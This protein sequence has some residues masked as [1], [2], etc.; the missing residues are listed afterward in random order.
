GIADM[1]V[2]LPEWV[3]SFDRSLLDLVLA[4]EQEH[5]NA[6]DPMLLFGVAVLVCLMPWNLALIWQARRLRSAMEVDCDARVLRRYPD[7]ERYGL[8]LLAIAQR[9]SAASPI[10]VATM[11][12]PAANLSRRFAAMKDNQI[13]RIRLAALCAFGII[14]I[15]VAGAIDSPALHAEELSST[16]AHTETFRAAQS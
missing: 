11:S 5:R 4:H 1:E 2:V 7:T 9:R 15:V 13:S 3:L 8:L 16:V 6:R 14:A 10:L 12:E